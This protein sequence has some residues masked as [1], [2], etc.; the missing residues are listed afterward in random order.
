[1]EYEEMYPS[2]VEV[3]DWRCGSRGRVLA[4]QVLEALSSNFSPNPAPPKSVEVCFL[5][6]Q[7]RGLSHSTSLFCDGYFQDRVSQAGFEPRSY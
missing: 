5:F 4:S 6:F 1:M 2:N 7:Y 3:L